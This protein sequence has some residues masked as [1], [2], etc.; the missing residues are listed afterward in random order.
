M[1]FRPGSSSGE[2]RFRVSSFRSRIRGRK[3]SSSTGAAADQQQ[4][5]VKSNGGKQSTT[6]FHV[7][8]ENNNELSNEKSATAAVGD[9]SSTSAGTD[10]INDSSLE[11][12]PLADGGDD[13]NRMIGECGAKT[14]DNEKEERDNVEKCADVGEGDEWEEEIKDQV[15]LTDPKYKANR[16]EKSSS[17]SKVVNTRKISAPPVME[18]QK[19]TTA[20]SGSGGAAAGPKKNVRSHSH[21]N[22]NSLLKYKCLLYAS[23]EKKLTTED[24]DKMRKKSLS[25]VAK[26][27]QPNSDAA[28]SVKLIRHEFIDEVD[29]ANCDSASRGR[30]KMS[31]SDKVAA[32]LTESKK[33]RSKSKARKRRG[34]RRSSVNSSSC[35]SSA[36]NIPLVLADK[37]KEEKESAAMLGW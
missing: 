21:L 24:F 23:A 11:I 4:S 31:L 28:N 34:S 33:K 16:I 8:Q 10:S 3:P 29:H 7:D 1:W 30:A 36:V 12:P 18:G 37:L 9:T 5:P 22:L 20:A 32:K 6:T 27:A 15:I 17:R 26:A 19:A 2:D 13:A 25:E 14:T 35:N